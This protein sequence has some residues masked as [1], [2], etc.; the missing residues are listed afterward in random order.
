MF[1]FVFF[2]L[3]LIAIQFYYML[4]PQ[5]RRGDQ[6]QNWGEGRPLAYLEGIA[7]KFQRDLFGG[8]RQGHFARLIDGRRDESAA[9]D[10]DNRTSTGR[11]D[12]GLC[13]KLQ[14]M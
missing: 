2:T 11:P 1:R 6:N 7:A 3:F 12:V 10:Q 9:M 8:W 4:F 13:P 14:F 5:N